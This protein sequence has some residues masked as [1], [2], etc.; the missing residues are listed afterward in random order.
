MVA[1]FFGDLIGGAVGSLF[2]QAGVSNSVALQ[3]ELMAEQARINYKYSQ[4]DLK[5]KWSANR[6][7]LE[8]AGYNPMLALAGVNSNSNW[9]SQASIN[10]TGTGASYGQGVSNAIARQQAEQQGLLIDSEVFKNNADSILKEQQA[11]TQ[12]YE[13][14]ER[15]NHADELRARAVL[16]SKQASYEDKRQAM[17]QLYYSKQI[18]RAGSEIKKNNA[19][20]MLQNQRYLLDKRDADLRYSSNAFDYEMK[21]NHYNPNTKTGKFNRTLYDTG[22]AI[23][24]FSGHGIKFSMPPRR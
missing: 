18:E 2:N 11:I 8:N 13:Q 10:D 16:A 14:N 12:M 21:Y 6:Q 5:T 3:K 1:G 9:A 20:I 23:S 24:D 4:K 22:K 19:L 15:A 7:G 17:E